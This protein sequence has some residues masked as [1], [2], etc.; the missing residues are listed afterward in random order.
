MDEQT[1]QRY[2]ELGRVFVPHAPIDQRALFAG[3]D[4]QIGAIMDAT[5]HTGRH[6]ILF[7]ERGVGKTSLAQVFHNFL[8]LNGPEAESLGSSIF[9]PYA[10]CDSSD[11]FSTIWEKVFRQI[12]VVENRP[13]MG[14]LAAVDESITNLASKIKG[15]CTPDTVVG[16]LEFLATDAAFVIVTI[17]EFDRLSDKNVTTLFADTI[18]ALSDRRID[19][20]L[21]LVGVADNVNDLIQ[22]HASAERAC[23]QVRVPRMS[24]DELAQI[25]NVGLQSVQMI[26]A[27]DALGFI[28]SL[29]QGLPHYTHLLGLTAGRAALKSDRLEVTRDDVMSA[30]TTAIN[31]VQETISS[32][33]HN[34][35]MSAKKTI[36]P[37]VLLACALAHLDERGTFAAADVSGPMSRIM[38]KAY[39]VTGFAKNLHD[40]CEPGRGPILQ[41]MGIP[42]R[43]RYRFV[44]PLMQPFV[45]MH[46]LEAGLI[47]ED[48][49]AVQGKLNL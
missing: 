35:V 44:N 34:S 13:K 20:T 37:Q 31:N 30:M 46:G 15:R 22:E 10:S 12:E 9:V 11:D 49:L 47:T 36:Y 26:I 3:R 28:I 16:L 39:D 18:K 14:F 19:V 4:E 6:V 43:F 1:R 29:S 23:I 45:I 24:S 8:P 38:K 25:I 40:L 27:D 17:D 41:R 33:Y 48:E 21:V 2:F 32:G 7:G 42:K 5:S